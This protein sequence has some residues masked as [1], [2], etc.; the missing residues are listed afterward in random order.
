MTTTHTF[1]VDI[2]IR[3][4]KNDKEKALIYARITVDGE[5]KEISLKESI[6]VSEWHSKSETV[7]GKSIRVKSINNAISETR[8]GIKHK[9]RWMRAEEIEITAESVKQYYL[10]EAIPQKGKQL[11]DLLDYFS[12]IYGD[13]LKKG[14]F[15]NYKTTIAYIKAFANQ[16]FGNQT[17][18]LKQVDM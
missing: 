15:K 18:Y 11:L 13:K 16:Q 3:R 9:Y 5:T 17:V 10:G 1:A 4:N 12:K 7:T 6:A 8:D 14:G 2:I